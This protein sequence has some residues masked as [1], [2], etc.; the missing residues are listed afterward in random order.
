LRATLPE[1]LILVAVDAERRATCRAGSAALSYGLAGAVLTEL[2]LLGAVQVTE[3]GLLAVAGASTADELLDDALARI[4][5]SRARD[6]K[7]WV[8]ALAGRSAG[9]HPRLVRRLVHAEVLR[10]ERRRV[11]GVVPVAHYAV[12]DQVVL[13][14]LR[15]R[16]RAGLLG[17]GTLD[18]RTASLIGLVGAC[19]L[20]D[21]LVARD[22]RRTARRRAATIGGGDPA[23]TAVS[24]AIRDAQAA[25]AAGVTA[26]AVASTVPTSG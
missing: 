9:L 16:L 18:S 7:G 10:E 12:A 3:R 22:D 15:R 21:G 14:G 6:V 26:A 4:R 11:L 5:A 13:A 8:R 25:V 2:L 20:V 19:G 17:R 1:E 24:A 23:G